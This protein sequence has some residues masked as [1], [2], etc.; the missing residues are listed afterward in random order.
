V[1]TCDIPQLNPETQN[2]HT[3]K[4]IASS[5]VF[6]GSPECMTVTRKWM[7]PDLILGKCIEGIGDDEFKLDDEQRQRKF[8][9]RKK[10]YTHKYG[11]YSGWPKE[12]TTYPLWNPADFRRDQG[13]H[14]IY[15]E[16]VDYLP[17]HM[18]HTGFHFHNYF[19]T[20]QNL[21]KKYMTYGHPVREAEN[22]T[23]GEMHPDLDLMVDCVLRRSTWKNRHNTLSSRLE[24]FEGRIPIA[25]GLEGYTVARHLELEKIL[26]DDE[27]GH[28]KSWH[29]NPKSKDWYEKIP[30]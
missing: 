10:K 8:A 19:E 9:W 16:N 5:M 1:Q 26:M 18:G 25:Y 30:N 20:T 3:A 22:M 2:C 13:G 14:I 12:K 23:V 24:E 4:V 15:F 17:F 27:K 11:N 29:D 7:H 28:D 21:R 6:E